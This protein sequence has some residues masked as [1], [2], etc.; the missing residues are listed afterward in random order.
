MITPLAF[1]HRLWINW[2]R[3]RYA[4]VPVALH[5]D[6]VEISGR[7]RFGVARSHSFFS[8]IGDPLMR[9]NV[10]NEVGKGAY[11]FKD[12]P[13]LSEYITKKLKTYVHNK[14]VHPHSHKFR[15]IWPRN[16]WPEGTQGEFG[17]EGEEFSQKVPPVAR[18]HSPPPA[19]TALHPPAPA[20]TAS[21]AMAASAQVPAA[22]PAPATAATIASVP[23]AAQVTTPAGAPP[24]SVP[25]MPSTPPEPGPALSMS[26]EFARERAQSFTDYEGIFNRDDTPPTHSASAGNMRSMSTAVPSTFSSHNSSNGAAAGVVPLAT[27]ANGSTGGSSYQTMR[28]KVTQW[29]NRRGSTAESNDDHY[30]PMSRAAV[31]QQPQ[32]PLSPPQQPGGTSPE[33]GPVVRRPSASEQMKALMQTARQ[34][35][36]FKAASA[37]GSVFGTEG[38]AAKRAGDTEHSGPQ[39]DTAQT[40]LT[41]LQREV[42]EDNL[43]WDLEVQ[44]QINR[45]MTERRRAL[46]A[47]SYTGGGDGSMPNS[48][49]PARELSAR[50]NPTEGT[51]VSASAGSNSS[52]EPAGNRLSYRIAQRVLAAHTR[53]RRR[54]L[55][56]SDEILVSSTASAPPAGDGNASS[57]HGLSASSTHAAGAGTEVHRCRSYDNL[58]PPHTEPGPAT[59][60]GGTAGSRTRSYSIDD[61]RREIMDSMF[62]IR[63]VEGL[64]GPDSGA[65]TQLDRP[66]STSYKFRDRP[67]IY[68]ADPYLAVDDASYGYSSQRPMQFAQTG[69][70]SGKGYSRYSSPQSSPTPPRP[71][72]RRPTLVYEADD[73]GPESERSPG[74]TSAPPVRALPPRAPQPA[75]LLTG[76]SSGYYTNTNTSNSGNPGSGGRTG[77]GNN[78]SNPLHGVDIAAKFAEFKAR[79]LQSRRGQGQRQEQGQ[80]HG[81]GQGHAAGEEEEGGDPHSGAMREALLGPEDDAAALDPDSVGSA[82]RGSTSG[83]TG[84]GTATGN[85]GRSAAALKYMSSMIRSKIQSA[86]SPDSADKDKTT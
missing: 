62:L 16:W 71:D 70:G 7:I 60:V 86:M 79:H 46:S 59:A 42:A 39:D 81:Q 47:A 20:S 5:L 30:H 33:P 75:P 21:A 50:S 4:S 12:F 25:R 32:N 28:S 43:A 23:R 69:S 85:G 84:A 49:A 72:A 63:L 77:T 37:S 76:P 13:Q 2:P 40:S 45:Y 44:N 48:P 74:P 26:D 27:H 9:I 53:S 41:A 52:P 83:Y 61:F 55:S 68:P 18:P 82:S 14:I 36:L 10:R 66:V 73:G 38:I 51:S 19:P 64:G 65:A 57:A 67:C 15:L 34:S 3:D 31:Q 24:V 17:G 80:G 54:S 22:V 58:E 6:L 56:A 11:K 35:S 78:T 1:L 29:M 8:F